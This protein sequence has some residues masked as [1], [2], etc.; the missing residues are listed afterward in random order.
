MRYYP[1]FLDIQN[2]PVVVIGGGTIA[3]QKMENLLAAGANV[4][5]VSP[6]LNPEMQ[7]LKEEGRFVFINRPYQPGDIEGAELVFVATD[8]RSENERVWQEGRERHIWVNAVDDIPN[9]DFIMPGIVRKGELILAI[10][11]SGTSPAMARKVREDI[12]EFLTD[13][14][15]ELLDL[16]AEIRRELRDSGTNVQNCAH[17][18]R[19]NN[20]VWNAALDGEVKKMLK[21][22][23]RADAKERILNLLLAPSGQAAHV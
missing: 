17:C 18:V 13:E 4:T 14:D 16:A 9:C 7:A 23:R 3:H 20:D 15:A 10:S 11:T 12:E 1:V 5:V 22:G 6:E 19:N 8:D 21:E 2:K